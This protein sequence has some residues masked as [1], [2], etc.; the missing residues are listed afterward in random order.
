[1]RWRCERWGVSAAAAKKY[2]AS[3]ET[4]ITANELVGLATCVRLCIFDG[5]G[6]GVLREFGLQAVPDE[7]ADHQQSGNME[8]H[9][10]QTW[11]CVESR[12]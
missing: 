5:L 10:V 9:Q 1:M 7:T 6:N 4:V 12:N 11:G 8:S 3:V 2:F